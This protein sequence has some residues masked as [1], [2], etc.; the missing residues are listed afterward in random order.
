MIYFSGEFYQSVERKENYINSVQT[1]L[2]NGGGKNISRLIYK[3][4]I[5]QIPYPGNT[6]KEKKARLISLKNINS[7]IPKKML[8]N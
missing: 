3:A 1:P 7:N 5:A 4:R 6:L 8:T 2:E